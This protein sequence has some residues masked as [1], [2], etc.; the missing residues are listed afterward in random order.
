[1]IGD[2]FHTAAV[3]E[4]A[5]LDFDADT[6]LRG[7]YAT[8]R[9]RTRLRRL[10]VG[11]PVAAALA[12]GGV[13]LP[14]VISPGASSTAVAAYAFAAAPAGA[15]P[16]TEV[17]GLDLGFLPAGIGADL[18]S[19]QTSTFR[20]GTT[21]QACFED[22]CVSG[23]SVAVTRADGLTLADYLRTDW[24]G[25]AT[26]TTVGGRPAL[27]NG[28]RGDDASGLLWSPQDGVVVEVHLGGDRAAQ[29]REIVE[30]MSL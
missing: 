5:A 23:L 2:T 22:D 11:A 27:A 1:M 24:F 14:S 30:Q 15:A 7:V 25:D 29:L 16:V 13:T 21:T 18:V 6:V 9:R 3:A 4:T 8:H 17:D 26:E 12:I 19:S 20:D 10:A 28:I